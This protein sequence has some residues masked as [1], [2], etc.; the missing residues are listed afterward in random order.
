MKYKTNEAQR[1]TPA[2]PTCETPCETDNTYVNYGS[3]K[4]HSDKLKTEPQQ[5]SA[6]HTLP[7]ELVGD[8]AVT[9]ERIQDLLQQQKVCNLDRSVI[10]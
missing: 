9:A 6:K 3:R 4:S 2:T 1:D 10:W 8:N 5:R 7:N